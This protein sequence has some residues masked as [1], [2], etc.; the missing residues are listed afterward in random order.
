V[1][2]KFTSDVIFDEYNIIAVNP[3]SEILKIAEE[4]KDVKD[5]EY[6][7]GMVYREDE[8]RILYLTTRIEVQKGFIM[9]ASQKKNTILST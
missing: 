6:L 1:K 3:R 2:Q 9:T 8:T 7:I 4:T 5:F